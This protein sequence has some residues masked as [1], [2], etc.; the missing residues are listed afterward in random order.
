MK[1]TT[2]IIALGLSAFL[3]LWLIAVPENLIIDFIENSLIKSGVKIETEDFKK[4][5]FYNFSIKRLNVTAKNNIPMLTIKDVEARLNFTSVVKLTPRIYFNGNVN[6]GK[7]HGN[8]SL[9]GAEGASIITGSDIDIHDIPALSRLG[10]QGKG[11]LTF[12]LWHMNNLSEIK[13]SLGDANTIASFSGIGIIP[14]DIFQNVRG[15]LIIENESASVKSLVLEG[16]GIYARVKGDISRD[17]QNLKIEVMADSSQP[18][19]SSLKIIEQFK[20]SP[21]YYVIPLPYFKIPPN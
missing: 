1:K 18:G 16:R 11:K 15:T 21:G 17:N 6:N 19:L 2:I 12:D 13:F 4:G 10:I 5:L 14:L 3:G 8:I 20:V 9:K 7:I